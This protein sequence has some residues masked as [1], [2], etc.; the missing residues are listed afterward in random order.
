[1]NDR[2][3]RYWVINKNRFK[4]EVKILSKKI[5]HELQKLKYKNWNRTLENLAEIDIDKAPREFY[6]TK[7]KL[8]GVGKSTTNITCMEYLDRK[9]S[10]E[11]GISD[12]M[13]LH[14]ADSFKPLDKPEFNYQNFAKRERQWSEAQWALNMAQGKINLRDFNGSDLLSPSFIFLSP[15]PNS[16]RRCR[17][18]HEA[19]SYQTSNQHLAFKKILTIPTSHI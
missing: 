14:A 5:N 8:G 9:E 15:E 17:M 10:A 16:R 12:L 2:E 13:A 6:S 18:G 19:E 1:M 4:T 7:K 3:Y 11:Q